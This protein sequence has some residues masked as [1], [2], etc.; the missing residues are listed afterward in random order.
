[1]SYLIVCLRV[2]QWALGTQ[3]H[4]SALTVRQ[5]SECFPVHL[6]ERERESE[7]PQFRVGQLYLISYQPMQLFPCP[8]TP[9]RACHICG[10]F[11]TICCFVV[12]G[13][14][15]LAKDQANK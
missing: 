2:A 10:H 1:M 9:S 8:D 13:D 6:P 4:A 11:A 5:L 3:V 15:E 12:T 7:W 14:L